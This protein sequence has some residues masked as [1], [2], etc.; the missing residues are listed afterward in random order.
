MKRFSFLSLWTVICF[1][2]AL[3]VVSAA[4]KPGYI[5]KT[6]RVDSLVAMLKAAG[7]P[8]FEGKWHYLGPFDNEGGAGFDAVYPPEKEIDLTKTY[9]GKGN[10]DV[11]WKQFPDFKVG[12]MNNLAQSPGKRKRPPEVAAFS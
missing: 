3:A 10:Q 9:K 4:P 8:T 11:A 5:K 12:A 2:S 7:L 6:N 1:L